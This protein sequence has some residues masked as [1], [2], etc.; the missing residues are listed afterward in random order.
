MKPV[1]YNVE[2][3]RRAENAALF[4][5]VLSTVALVFCLALTLIMTS[6][7]SASGLG[8]DA[9]NSQTT[10]VP[11]DAAASGASQPITPTVGIPLAV[12]SRVVPNAI[13]TGQAPAP[14]PVRT[15]GTGG[16]TQ[17]GGGT[18][19][20]GFPWLPVVIVGLGALAL[21]GFALM[22]PRRA[23]PATADTSRAYSVRRDANVS[24]TET[25]T[26]TNASGV[27]GAS[28]QAAPTSVTCP[29]CQ[30]VNDIK[31]N[32]CHDCGQDLRP[33]RAAL[34]AALAP[35]GS[36]ASPAEVVTDDMPYLETLDRADEQLEYVL[37]RPRVVL[38][39]ATSSDVVI[40]AGFTGWQTVSPTHAELRREQEGYILVDRASE[41]GTFV[42]DVRTGESIL[43][44]GDT[45]RLGDVRFIFH[46]PPPEDAQ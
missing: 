43:A 16:T 15:Q 21:A 32:F 24:T 20:G 39:T 26:T 42:N 5:L 8:S 22:R 6:G 30:A 33:T 7:S 41:S 40:D 38:G 46:I 36:L 10:V 11:G 17:Q 45:M 4:S 23:A 31:E 9:P 1:H 12:Q 27:A 14:S 34:M 35:A 37:S 28:P 44:D 25:I 18:S 29:N 3:V 13:P 19:Q 2:R